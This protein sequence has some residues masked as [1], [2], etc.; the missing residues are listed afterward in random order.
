MNKIDLT[1]RQAIVTGGAR[2]I[3]LAIARRLLQSGAGVSLWDVDA[4]AL[5]QAKTELDPLGVVHTAA[6]DITNADSTE[7]AAASSAGALG[8]LDILV[9]NAGVAG[10]NAK[11]W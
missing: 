1:H 10:L 7:A 3:G 11:T 5:A 4:A 8:K 9:N 2:G 6:V